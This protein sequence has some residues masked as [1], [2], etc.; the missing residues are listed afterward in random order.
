MF[1][2]TYNFFNLTTDDDSLRK[3]QHRNTSKLLTGVARNFDWEGPKL[4][5]NLWRYFCDVFRWRNSDNVT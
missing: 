5:K 3:L 4:E 1:V 2:T